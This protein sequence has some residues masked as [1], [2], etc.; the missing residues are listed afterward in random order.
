MA[1]GGS[2]ME[3]GF[4]VPREGL[5]IKGARHTCG[6]ISVGEE[7][8]WADLPHFSQPASGWGFLNPSAHFYITHPSPFLLLLHMVPCIGSWPQT[9]YI[10]KNDF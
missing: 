2:E 9:Q 5:I 6:L 3:A 4:R 7:V 1:S 10:A 8:T